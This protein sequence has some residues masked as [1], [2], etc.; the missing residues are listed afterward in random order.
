[1]A[2]WVAKID[3]IRIE[4]NVRAK[5]TEQDLLDAANDLE[6]KQPREYF[7]SLSAEELEDRLITYFLG[8]KRRIDEADY[9]CCT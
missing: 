9:V 8:K 7:E 4:R 5:V 1:M 3:P 2:R 6:A